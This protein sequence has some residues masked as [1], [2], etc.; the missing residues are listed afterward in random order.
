MEK[1]E[2][3]FRKSWVC[4]F[5]LILFCGQLTFLVQQSF[6][7]DLIG[8]RVLE[9]EGV[10]QSKMFGEKTKL[11]G[12]G[13]FVR[14]GEELNIGAESWVSLVMADST[15]RKFNGPA[16]ITIEQDLRKT[17]GGILARLG[18]AVA[19]VLFSQEEEKPEAVM[20]T[21]RV[22]GMEEIKDYLPLVVHPA[23]GSNVLEKP[24]KFKWRKVEAVP[25]YRVSVYSRDRLLWQG[26]TSDSHIDC[27]AEYCNLVPGEQYYWV[28]EGLIGN[29]ALR[30]KAA[31]FR[32]LSED[33][34]SE[35]YK[36]LQEADSSCPD[37][38]LAISVKV[39]LCLNLNLYREALDLVDSY[40][41]E[42]SF[43][44]RAYMLRAEI[45][46]KMGLFEDA[47]FDYKNASDMPSMK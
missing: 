14:I 46:E 19:G 16:T 35:F 2:C 42:G 12:P 15:V 47:F 7:S 30:S 20:T 11:L 45:N 27:P 31:D 1:S 32:V 40:W 21:R 17:G 26:T 44:R 9:V 23:P 39:R 4:F 33:T 18:S 3:V 38:A 5:F 29:A 25:L 41:K 22:E 8:A 43:D 24:A 36:A 37:P 34:R 10:V 28:V 6:G 13:D